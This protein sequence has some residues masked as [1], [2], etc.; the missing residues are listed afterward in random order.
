MHHPKESEWFEEDIRK[1]CAKSLP[2]VD[3]WTGGFPCQ[4]VSM[5]GERKG[6]YG[7][8]TGLFFE[9]VRLLR[10]RGDNKPRWII[11]E[12]V[13]GIFSSGGGRDFAI[14]LYELA[15]LGYSIEYALVNSKDFGVPQSRERV[16][17]IGDITGRSTGKIFPLGRTNK[18]AIR[19]VIGGSQGSR[20]YDTKGLS[21]TI[22][23]GSGGLGSKTGL[24]FVARDNK[25]GVVT[26]ENCGTIDA[27]YHH[28]L[29]P[30][31]HRTG[32][33][34]SNLPRAMLTP[35]K[36]NKRQNGRRIKEEDEEMFTLTAT[37]IHGILHKSRIR[38]LTPLE[39]FRLQGV[40]DEYFY[41]VADICSDTQLYKQIGN[42]V[43]VPVVKAIGEKIMFIEESERI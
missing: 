26:K 7:E 10:E 27:C 36:L 29:G 20:V 37:D 21:T 38:R 39:A 14:V 16:Y 32:V 12:N 18:K 22:T 1:V 24:Y 23:S 5:A 17:I 30:N 35:T 41:R 8:R 31:Q 40:P 25:K 33:L 9:F 19:Q 34:E 6:L 28:G 42:A 43:T 4:D 15:A 3:V 11:L 13:K 2:N